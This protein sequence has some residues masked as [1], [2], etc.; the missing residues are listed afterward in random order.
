MSMT[1]KG[2]K[3]ADHSRIEL[4]YG[5]ICLSLPAGEEA[6]VLLAE[7]AGWRARGGDR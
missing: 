7:E 1:D 5:R 2:R 6:E 4:G 3:R